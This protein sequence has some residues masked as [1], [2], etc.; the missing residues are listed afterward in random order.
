MLV[1]KRK[2]GERI[3]IGSDIVITVTEIG[4]EHVRLGIDAPPEK[5][6]WRDELLPLSERN[7]T[8]DIG[9]EG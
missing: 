8:H 6:I 3:V 7:H 5:K 9:G 2:V 1:L 4:W